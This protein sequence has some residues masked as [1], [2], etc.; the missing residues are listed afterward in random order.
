MRLRSLCLWLLT[1]SAVILL[2]ALVHI[3]TRV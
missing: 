2:L 1:V 3:V